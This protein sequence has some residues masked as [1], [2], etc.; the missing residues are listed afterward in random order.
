MCAECLCAGPP[1]VRDINVKKQ[2]PFYKGAL[3]NWLWVFE[4]RSLLCSPGWVRTWQLSCL[5]FPSAGIP[6]STTVLGFLL[7]FN[8]FWILVLLWAALRGDWLHIANLLLWHFPFSS[9]PWTCKVPCNYIG[10]LQGDRSQVGFHILCVY[11]FKMMEDFVSCLK[12]HC[13]V[14]CEWKCASH[15]I[16]LASFWARVILRAIL[17]IF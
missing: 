9:M 3:L 11:F 6:K 14:D 15:Y 4:T 7:A 17:R 12:S 13:P 1:W 8:L 2:H 5:S 16:P 10:F